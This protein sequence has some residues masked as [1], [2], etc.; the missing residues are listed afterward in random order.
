[1]SGKL[2]A[3]AILSALFGCEPAT[4]QSSSALRYNAQMPLIN[5]GGGLAMHAPTRVVMVMYG[6][7]PSC[8]GPSCP[9]EILT[10][11]VSHLGGSEYLK[12]LET[13][14]DTAGSLEANLSYGGLAFDNGSVHGLNL[15]WGPGVGM[16]LNAMPRVI[17][18]DVVPFFGADSSTIYVVVTS[19][20]VSATNDGTLCG[21]HSSYPRNDGTVIKYAWVGSRNVEQ[22][23]G[24]INGPNAV[25]SPNGNPLADKMASTL[26]HEL[27]ET[28]TAPV[29]G[30]GWWG[31]GGAGHD[32][33]GDLCAGRFEP[34]QGGPPGYPIPLYHWNVQLGEQKYLLQQEYV[35]IPTVGCALRNP[36]GRNYGIGPPSVALPPGPAV[37]VMTVGTDGALYH[38]TVPATTWDRVS[39]RG[40]IPWGSKV[41][42][43]RDYPPWIDTFSIAANGSIRWDA[44]VGTTGSLWFLTAP[45]TARSGTTPAA[46]V[47][48]SDSLE[49]FVMGPNKEIKQLSY[50]FGVTNLTTISPTGWIHDESDITAIERSGV[51]YLFVTSPEGK[52][53]T[54]ERR[55]GAWGGWISIAGTGIARLG[56]TP[57]AVVRTSGVDVFVTDSISKV[58]H[59]SYTNPSLIPWPPFWDAVSDSGLVGGQTDVVA[60]VRGDSI[61][62]LFA[63]DASG[64][65]KTAESSGS[66]PVSWSPV[67]TWT[68]PPSA[69]PA[70]VSTDVNHMD[71]FINSADLGGFANH[72]DSGSWTPSGWY[73]IGP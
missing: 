26:A 56:T 16:A 12:I 20:E 41:A 29:L 64:I 44:V 53:Y 70:V 38:N 27:M 23:C 6:P 10:Y 9:A 21:G 47:T 36:L 45:G 11:L 28:I 22:S 72:W 4:D 48:G 15:D 66:W 54:N 2:R 68:A 19:P 42:A 7:W 63:A 8:A 55:G 65:V 17:E 35:N 5:Y 59:I 31:A 34:M 32:E 49:V 71:L 33:I 61:I 1:M 46:V 39:G 51:I 43:I 50:S 25:F 73:S 67:G 40:A 3:L 37:E 24:S 58:R 13:Y 60:V 30:V 18:D 52:V 14:W 57:A 62:D 69:T